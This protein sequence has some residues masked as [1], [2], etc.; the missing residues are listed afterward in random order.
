REL[1]REGK[2]EPCPSVAPRGKGIGV[3]KIVKQF[4]LLLG[5]HAD[6]AVSHGKLDPVASI[7]HLAHPQ[8]DLALFR[9]LTSIA[10]EIEQNLLEPQG[11]RSECANVLWGFNDE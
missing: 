1:A 9:E 8:R 3:G 2:A 6:A 10:Q 4:R 5:G 7:H 11:V